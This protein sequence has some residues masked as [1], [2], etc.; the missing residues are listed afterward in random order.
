MEHGLSFLNVRALWHLNLHP[1]SFYNDGEPTTVEKAL[2]FLEEGA[3]ILDVGAEPTNPNKGSKK[4]SPEEEKSASH[5]F[6][7]ATSTRNR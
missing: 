4:V 5:P 7:E 2:R 6:F 1:S 3:D